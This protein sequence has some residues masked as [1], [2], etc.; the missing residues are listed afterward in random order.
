[1]KYITLYERDIHVKNFIVMS[2]MSQKLFKNVAWILDPTA[3]VR[4]QLPE[5]YLRR[6][7]RYRVCFYLSSNFYDRKKKKK[8]F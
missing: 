2:F 4:R 8:K 6:V 3:T 7:Q 1:M 5:L